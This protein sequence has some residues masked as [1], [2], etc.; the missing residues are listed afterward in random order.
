MLKGAFNHLYAFM[1]YFLFDSIYSF[2][3]FLFIPN[4]IAIENEE[5]GTKKYVAIDKLL[6]V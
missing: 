6:S 4:L 5:V 3:F 2:S 1:I